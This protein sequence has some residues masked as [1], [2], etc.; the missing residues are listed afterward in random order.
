M[1]GKWVRIVYILLFV[2]SFN[3]YLFKRRAFY[4]FLH[5]LPFFF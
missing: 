3:Y 4:C 2:Y 1:L 5:V